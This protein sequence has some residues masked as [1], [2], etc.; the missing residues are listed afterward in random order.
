MECGEP[1][2]HRAAGRHESLPDHLPAKHPLPADLRG[3][4]AEEV[5]LKRLEVENVEEVLDR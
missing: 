5:N 1:A 3:Q 2:F 4:A